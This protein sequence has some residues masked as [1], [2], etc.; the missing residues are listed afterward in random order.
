MSTPL[1][2]LR[3]DHKHFLARR[4]MPRRLFMSPVSLTTVCTAGSARTPHWNNPE[5]STNQVRSRQTDLA[6]STGSVTGAVLAARA[7]EMTMPATAIH[8]CGPS[9]VPW[10][11]P[12]S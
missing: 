9:M 1:R 7:T 8:F 2:H 4:S 11:V 12:C 10:P 5:S 6:A 3:R